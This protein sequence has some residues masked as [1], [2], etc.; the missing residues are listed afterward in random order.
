ML[1]YIPDQTNIKCVHELKCDTLS[2]IQEETLNWIDENTNFLSE[3]KDQGF[4]KIIPTLLLN[5]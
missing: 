2:A 5:S 4:W 1:D 3:K